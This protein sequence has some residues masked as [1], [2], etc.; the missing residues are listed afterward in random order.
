MV[1][2][3][4]SPRLLTSVLGSGRRLGGSEGEVQPAEATGQIP[5]ICSRRGVGLA[6]PRSGYTVTSPGRRIW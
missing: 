3:A 4:E 1:A 2:V 5:A 6:W